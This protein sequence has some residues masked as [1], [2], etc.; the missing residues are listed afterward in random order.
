[1]IYFVNKACSLSSGVWI[2]RVPHSSGHS[3]SSVQTQRLTHSHITNKDV[4]INYSASCLLAFCLY[5]S[6]EGI[7]GRVSHRE[8]EMYS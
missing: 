3:T 7:D 4:P 8:D 6:K 5:E 2:R 1:M